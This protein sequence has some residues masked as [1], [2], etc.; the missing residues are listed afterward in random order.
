M[1]NCPGGR[2]D[3]LEFM[4]KCN[5]G[6]WFTARLDSRW[7]PDAFVG[8]MASL[9]RSVENASQPETGGRNNLRT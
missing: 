5:P 3:G 4:S 2:S 6:Y 1:Y 9:M 7:I 8:P